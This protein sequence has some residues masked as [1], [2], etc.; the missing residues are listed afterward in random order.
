MTYTSKHQEIGDILSGNRLDDDGILDCINADYTDG[1]K[2]HFPDTVRTAN[3]VYSDLKDGNLESALEKLE[4]YLK[5]PKSSMS[6]I[7][8]EDELYDVMQQNQ[9]HG[10]FKFNY[11]KIAETHFGLLALYENLQP[12]L[13]KKKAS[14][15]APDIMYGQA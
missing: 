15:D 1:E 11:E 4:W 10:A 2:T 7:E 9:L 6:G 8:T 14:K 13:K 12:K 5:D 3:D